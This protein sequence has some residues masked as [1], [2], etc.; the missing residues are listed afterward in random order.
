MLQAYGQ[1]TMVSLRSNID[2]NGY[3]KHYKEAGTSVLGD[4]EFKHYVVY[5]G[6]SE[7]DTKEMS[8]LIDGIVEECKQLNIE[9]LT[10]QQL[11]ELNRK[12]GD[13]GK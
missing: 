3:F 4:K 2:V 6:S 1:S 5:K 11:E 9:T 12:W 10:P 13:Y 8:V 7:Y